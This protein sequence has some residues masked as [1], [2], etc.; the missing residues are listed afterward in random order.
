[1]PASHLKRKIAPKTWPILRKTTTFITRPKPKGQPIGLTLPVVVV[2]RDVLGVAQTAGQVRRILRSAEVK[3]NGT[4]VHDTDAAVGFMD[5]LETVDTKHRLVINANNTLDIVPV[6]KGEEFIVEKVT[7]L[8]SLRGGRTQLNCASGRTAIVE[9]G[10]YRP[11]DSVQV[12]LDG[13]L[14]E[15]YP[16]QQGVA[17]LLTGGKHIGMTGKVVDLAG[18]TVTVEADGITFTTRKG[19]AYVVG[20]EKPAITLK[21]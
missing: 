6:R 3:V 16:L 14:G 17:V 11:G 1:M 18:G 9:K 5:I 7:G 21:E 4:R 2:L 13:K 20:K 19:N 15:R 8:T 12:T 10:A